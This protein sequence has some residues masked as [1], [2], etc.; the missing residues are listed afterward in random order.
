LNLK[1]SAIGNRQSAIL[2]LACCGAVGLLLVFLF[3]DCYQQDGGVHY[4]FA[5]WAWTHHE[6]F[7]G[8][9]TRPLFTFVYAFPALLGYQASRLFSVLLSVAAAWQTW[10]LA[11]HYKLERPELT[12]PFLFLQP[13]FFLLCSETMTEIIFAFVFVVALYLYE[14]GFVKIGAVV[15][16]FMLLARPEGFL[17]GVMWGVWMLFDKRVGEKFWQRI[18]WSL[19]LATGGVVWIVASWAITGDVLY[20]KHNWPPQWQ[21]A[22]YGSGYIF[23]YMIRLPEIVGPLLIPPFIVGLVVLILRKKLTYTTTSFL[24]LF[25]LH[26]I[27]WRFG[28][29]GSAGYPRYFVCVAPAIAI[30]TLN[31]WNEIATKCGNTHEVSVFLR[32]Y[33]VRAS[34][35]YPKTFSYLFNL[36]TATTVLVLLISFWLCFLYVD[37]AAWSRDARAVKEMYNWFKQNE[38]P[39]TKFVWSQAYQ[40]VLFDRDPF[41][42]PNFAYDDRETN[43]KIFR[44]LPK[45][46]LVF[47]D[48]RTGWAWHA[49]SA[50][51]IESL[52]Y[53][54]LHSRSYVLTG[55]VIKSYWVGYAGPRQQEFYLLYKE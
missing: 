4:I 31:G 33:F 47:W 11:K 40:N 29:F 34:A 8:V 7:V 17:L 6:M 37:A 20:I 49:V 10:R 26:S 16:S 42:K 1:Q 12:I 15:A 45:G 55:Y 23:G 35:L 28:I 3:L 48:D 25:V 43:L 51:D 18:F 41:E 46:T 53:K 19:L 14:K 30:I 44:E 5:R 52:G 36:Q 38:R 24:T 54:K 21:S 50:D 2:W 9:W 27:F 39:V 32:P 13:S 22:A